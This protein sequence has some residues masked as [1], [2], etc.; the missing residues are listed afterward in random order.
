M[1]LTISIMIS[2]ISL[3]VSLS[4]AVVAKETEDTNAVSAV[5]KPRSGGEQKTTVV[6]RYIPPM[7]GAPVGARL[8]SGGAR[9]GDLVSLVPLAP[10]HVGWTISDQPTLYCYLSKA[11]RTRLEL[12]LIAAKEVYP[13][14]EIR[15]EPP[16]KPGLQRMR[17]AE[18][19]IT[20][21]PNVEYE[22]KV[23]LIQNSAQRS[24]DILAGGI[25]RYVRPSLKL[26]LKLDSD[27]KRRLTFVYAEEG[28]W[29]DAITSVSNLID[30]T[31]GDATL[32]KQRAALLQQVGLQALAEKDNSLAK[33][34]DRNGSYKH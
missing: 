15:L 13:L 3:M 10:D 12:T 29:Y 30:A 21:K 17:L 8:V 22:W 25:I 20:L 28:L 27:N 2:A 23:S 4:M 19:G 33:K 7:R 26:Q 14:A 1:R 18:F 31:P 16:N 32:H 34:T 11:V 9:G 24:N 5:Q 6:P